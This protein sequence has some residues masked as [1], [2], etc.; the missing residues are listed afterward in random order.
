ML[1][2]PH[3][4]PSLSRASAGPQGFVMADICGSMRLNRMT[5]YAFRHLGSHLPRQ[6]KTHT[7]GRVRNAG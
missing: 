4:S 2:S 7:A 6:N 1:T 3:F 5:R